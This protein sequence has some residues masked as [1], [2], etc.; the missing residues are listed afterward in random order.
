MKFSL[1]SLLFAG[2]VSSKLSQINLIQTLDDINNIYKKK[3]I[4]KPVE[5]TYKLN[6]SSLDVDQN[7]YESSHHY[8]SNML[9]IHYS[10]IKSMNRSMFLSTQQNF[11]VRSCNQSK[12]RYL[13]LYNQAAQRDN[14]G[15]TCLVSENI[16]NNRYTSDYNTGLSA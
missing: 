4:S 10:I 15:L 16:S 12:P 3:K 11:K 13:V 9:I 2:H 6:P 1:K 5:I 7:I 14:T 8:H